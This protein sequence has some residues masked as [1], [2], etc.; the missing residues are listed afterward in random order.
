MKSPLLIRPRKAGS[1]ALPSGFRELP[2]PEDSIDQPL[3][4]C[5]LA[6]Q[7]APLAPDRRSLL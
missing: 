7:A 3:R 2:Q 6:Q 5:P 4:S 1:A